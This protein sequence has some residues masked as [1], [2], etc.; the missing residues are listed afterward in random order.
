MGSVKLSDL[1]PAARKSLGVAARPRRK[2]KGAAPRYSIET[3]FDG[4]LALD[5][6]GEVAFYN[7][8][9]RLGVL[10]P[11]PHWLLAWPEGK[12]EFDFL[13]VPAMLFVEVQGGAGTPHMGHTS[14]AGMARD[15][16]WWGEAMV[17]GYSVLPI[18]TEQ[19]MDGTGALLVQR[20]LIARGFA[21]PTR[22][23]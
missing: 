15:Y 20:I 3:P 2:P 9:R 12:H 4:T 13:F 8:C 16:Y 18:T 22:Q 19:A 6:E 1:P 21:R 14:K 17:M 11:V 7:W 5:S 23:E 10:L